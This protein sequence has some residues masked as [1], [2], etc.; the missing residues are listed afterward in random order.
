MSA[1]VSK[2]RARST[3][4]T[5]AAGL[6]MLAAAVV[7]MIVAAPQTHALRP[8]IVISHVTRDQLTSWVWTTPKHWVSV[9][10][11]PRP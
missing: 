11:A 9:D 2:S 8:A 10:R 6:L 5:G 7:M 1:V 3:W 4:L